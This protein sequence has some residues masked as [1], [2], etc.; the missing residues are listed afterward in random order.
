MTKKDCRTINILGT[1]YEIRIDP[2]DPM[3]K[4]DIDGYCDETTKTIV[5]QEFVPD[6][7]S[8]SDLRH[9]QKQVIRHELIHAFLFESGLAECS[10]WAKNEELVDFFAIQIPKMILAMEQVEVL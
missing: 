4:Y 2:D 8:K 6:D 10:S 5:V 9:F 1:D 3:F 7:R